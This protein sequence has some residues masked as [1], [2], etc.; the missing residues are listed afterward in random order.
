VHQLL[1]KPIA[2]DKL[3][4]LQEK[5][6]LFQEKL[7]LFPDYSRKNSLKES[8]EKEIKVKERKESIRRL[9]APLSTALDSFVYDLTYRRTCGKIET[10]PPGENA[11]NSICRTSLG[12]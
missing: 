3:G 6:W 7:W 5:L 10:S 2:G 4:F 12:L 9:T 1:I 8:K 11:F